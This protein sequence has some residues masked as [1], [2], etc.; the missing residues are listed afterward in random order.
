M[1]RRH[2]LV[3]AFVAIWA[4]QGAALA[5][6]NQTMGN[7]GSGPYA[8]PTTPGTPQPGAGE[9]RSKLDKIYQGDSAAKPGKSLT[10]KAQALLDV[11]ALVKSIDLPCEVSDANEVAAGPATV[12]GQTLNTKTFEV[13]C[14][15]GLG[16]L[17]VSQDPEKPYG[18][19][20]FAAEAQSA[21]A[22]SKG[23][24][25][26]ISCTLPVDLDT[27]LMATTVLA[28]LGV[29]CQ[30]NGIRWMG[31]SS[32]ANL[33][34]TEIAC[35]DGKG[36]VLVTAMPGSNHALSD[37]SCEDAIKRGIMCKLTN[38]GPPPI[39]IQTFKDALAQHGIACDSTNIRVAGQETV[40]KRHV[41]EFQCPQYPKGLVAFIPLEGNTAPFQTMDCAKAAK[42]MHIMCKLTN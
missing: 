4:V 37:M 18:F 30:T 11:T 17:L 12:N 19:S 31:A 8:N 16:Y 2:V 20:C 7:S 26:P 34:F 13:T 6:T 38:A 5:Q 42:E 27:K 35:T 28:H 15:S 32:K 24:P 36:Y 1:M 10:P 39:T 9:D 21:L 25:A 22:V 3:A 23:E 29:T 40:L 33:E 14:S 41:V